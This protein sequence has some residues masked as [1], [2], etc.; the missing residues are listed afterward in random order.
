M[1]ADWARQR[2]GRD[3]SMDS[4]AGPERASQ[5]GVAMSIAIA[6]WIIFAITAGAYL[7]ID[8]LRRHTPHGHAR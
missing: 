5:K 1:H 8:H 3:D 7:G 4:S 6:I 2:R